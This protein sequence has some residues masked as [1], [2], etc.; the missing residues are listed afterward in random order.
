MMAKS[1][2]AMTGDEIAALENEELAP[3]PEAAPE[4]EPVVEVAPKGGKS[5]AEPEFVAEPEEGEKPKVKADAGKP[6]I[7]AQKRRA[8]LTELNAVPQEVL[9]GEREEHKKTRALLQAQEVRQA[10]L[11]ERQNAL[12]EAWTRGQQAQQRQAAPEP[13][14]IPDVNQDP[15]AAI[16]WTQAQIRAD[17]EARAQ[18][19]REWGEQSQRQQAQTAE[20]QAAQAEWQQAYPAVTAYWEQAAAANPQI[21][22][23]YNALRQSYAAELKRLGWHGQHDIGAE[24]NRIETGHILNCYRSGTPIDEFVLGLAESRGWKPKDPDAEPE[25]QNGKA[26]EN[27][28]TLKRLAKAQDASDTL[29]GMGGGAGGNKISL[30]TLDRMPAKEFN[31]LIAKL[32][33][34]GGEDAVNRAMEK[35]YGVPAGRG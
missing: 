9:H 6:K 18:A 5:E 19:E 7:D 35:M 15:L 14:A 34:E 17:R 23:A 26:N 13:E 3:A 25:V 31:A 16:A 30:E 12:N 22:D 27:A 1:A 21:N 10:R 28:D 2:I 8:Q 24:L 33:R 20:Q 11:E 4:Q 29:S 32:T